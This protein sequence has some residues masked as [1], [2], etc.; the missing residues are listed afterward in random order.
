MFFFK[1]KSKKDQ[2]IEVRHKRLQKTDVEKKF[3][4]LHLFGSV[5]LYG[6]F[7]IV[8]VLIGFWGQS[9]MGPSLLPNQVCKSK[10]VSNVDFDYESDIKTK[11]LKEQRRQMVAP[12][13]KVDLTAFH[14]F[15]QKIEVLKQRLNEI[16]AL[17]KDTEQ[18]LALKQLIESFEEKHGLSLQV[19]DLETLLKI[20]NDTQRSRLLEE[21]LFILQEAT[22]KGIFD[23]TDVNNQI[24]DSFFFNVNQKDSQFVRLQSKGNALRFLRMNLFVMDTEYEVANALIH[25][26]KFGII[27]NLV[28]DK[29]K[30]EDKIR[31][32]V[33]KTPTLVVHIAKGDSIAE[34]GQLV[35]PEVY[36]RFAAYQK[37]I[38]KNETYGLGFNAVMAKK[39][40]LAFFLFCSTLIALKLLPSKIKR[41]KRCLA[42]TALVLLLNVALI[43]L[44]NELGSS[45]LFSNK[46]IWVAL[47]PYTAPVYLSSL[48]LTV[49]MDVS[50]GLLVS[51]F[52]NV[53]N[54]LI[55]HVSLEYFLMDV[56]ASAFAVYMCQKVRL[57]E[58]IARAGMA[59][60]AVLSVSAF[61]H[62]TFIQQ[63]P[64]SIAVQQAIAALGSG[65][66]TIILALGLLPI[67]ERLFRYTTD[68][69]LLE[70]TD[71]NHPLLRKLQMVA[72]GT[73]H[74]SLMVATLA[75]KVADEVGANPL[76]CR[77]C[78]L[79][80][81]VGK[82]MK[83]EYFTEN[84]K[85][86]ENPHE[87]QNTSMSA[88]ILKSHVKEGVELAKSYKLPK[89]ILDVIQQHHGTSIM[90]YFYQKALRQQSKNE[91]L[92]EQDEV[93]E[94]MFRYEGPK[95]QFKESA[96]ISLADAV[97]AASRSLTKVT[98]QTVEELINS[99]VKDR[100][101]ENQLNECNITLKDV[102]K[103]KK[104]FQFTLLN[105]LHA[106]VSYGKLQEPETAAQR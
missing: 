1:R 99:I 38:E 55:Q 17:S 25:I 52:I 51:F 62:S 84:Q 98:P 82:I 8:L 91:I 3:Y 39:V 48:L 92:G 15:S 101:E 57:R 75:E 10:I 4:F 95:P 16:A 106:R 79:Y 35:T 94:L 50:G 37:V 9:P 105:M 22:Q 85:A 5:G 2:S 34:G 78:A 90:Q 104:S 33:E 80:H 59:A 70:L 21:G 29:N 83:P 27:P 26:L 44:V 72:P 66:L 77:C 28:Y 60:S 32:F 87:K 65:A 68:I 43:R 45:S 18:Q 102:D 86:A 71:Y 41:S 76:I 88:L 46:L 54:A 64:P 53:I 47:L 42:I 7:F 74:H 73:Y 89:L 23:E 14:Q 61:I 24:N 69:T 100:I 93:D 40:F 67:F 20:P 31:Q 30:T 36:E 19:E 12:V 81:D 11:Q 13:Y 97:E 6:L 56:L 96:I 63:L 103:I 49:L 58:G